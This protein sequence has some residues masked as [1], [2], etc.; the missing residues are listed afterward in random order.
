MLGLLMAEPAPLSSLQRVLLLGFV[1]WHGLASVGSMANGTAAGDAIRTVTRAYERGLGVYQGW[2]MFAP[3]APTGTFWLEFVGLDGRGNEVARW[4]VYGGE[5][6]RD[7]PLLGYDRAHK[8]ERTLGKDNRR[9]GRQ[10]LLRRGCR[11]LAERD[12]DDEVVSLSIV[13]RRRR[14]QGLEDPTI[15]KAATEELRESLR[16]P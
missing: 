10:A 8:L 15:R 2:P 5:V 7:A 13:E 14:V 9:P 16:C 3:N 6:D 4:P 11:E 12:P 1:A